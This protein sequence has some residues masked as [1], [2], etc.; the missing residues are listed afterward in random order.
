VATLRMQRKS[1]YARFRYTENGQQKQYTVPLRTNQKRQALSRLKAVNEAESDIRSGIIPKDANTR[2]NY[3]PWLNEKGTSEIY[4]LTLEEAIREYLEYCSIKGNRE[5]TIERDSYCLNNL[6]K[7]L[8][9]K[10]HIDKLTTENIETFKKYFKD[11]KTNNGR[12]I[13]LAKIRAFVNWLI[14]HKKLFKDNP[15]IIE[16]VKAENKPISYL[17]EPDFD[18]IMESESQNKFYKQVFTF[19][20]ATGCR[21]SEPFLGDVERHGDNLWLVIYP[22]VSKT[23]IP[24]EILLTEKQADFIK[25]MKERRDPNTKLRHYTKNFSRHFKIVCR[26][27]G[28]EDLHFHNL[29]DTFA[30]MK[31]LETKDIYRVMK[32]L[33]HTSLKMTVKYANLRLSKV[34]SDFPSLSMNSTN[35]K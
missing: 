17:S 2:S 35:E 25:E 27:I 10:F 8:G 28:K 9:K 19:Y 22:D 12:N 20:R 3:F 7:V 31:Y 1:Y 21:L 24:R 23:G 26:E 11:K 5:R 33:G 16:M 18:K 32:E 34:A 29:R 13:D 15:P 14:R 30:V 4:S 6:V